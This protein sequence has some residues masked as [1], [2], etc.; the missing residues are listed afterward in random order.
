M[1]LR[2]TSRSS[3]VDIFEH[4]R[5]SQALWMIEALGANRAKGKPD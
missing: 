3:T 5:G 1:Y 2:K 4:M